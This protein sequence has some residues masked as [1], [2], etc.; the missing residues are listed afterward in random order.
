MFEYFILVD[1]KTTYRS[2]FFEGQQRT[3]RLTM[4][5]GHGLRVLGRRAAYLA[6]ARDKP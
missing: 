2:L 5:E 4:L 1:A 6:K 3:V